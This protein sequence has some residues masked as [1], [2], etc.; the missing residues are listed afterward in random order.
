[1]PAPRP[2]PT[3]SG[4]LGRTPFA[5]LL[6]Y[7][8]DKQLT[9]TF[10]FRAIDGATASV[11]V[12]AGRPAKAQ[13]SG[14]GIY[15]GQ[16]LLELG[17]IDSATLDSSLLAMSKER[18]LHGGILVASGAIT[19]DQLERGLRAQ[20]QRKL[21]HVAQLAPMTT[22]EFHAE[23]DG[24]S[25]F[26]GEP[27]PVDPLPSVW[28]AIRA[29]PSLEHAKAALDRVSKGRL[30][31][32]RAAQIDRLGLSAEERRWV[33]L[34]SMRPLRLEEF[35]ANAE[36]GERLAR[37]L[38]Y[39]LAITKQIELVGEEEPTSSNRRAAIA[40]TAA[41]AV[42]APPS[43][44]PSSP[45][46]VGRVALR[47][48]RH[49]TQPAIEESVVRAAADSRLTPPPGAVQAQTADVA[50]RRK[51]IQ[52]V[53]A[54]IDKQNYFE[55]LG[56]AAGASIDEVKN[57]YFQLAKAWHPDRLPA[58]LGDSRDACARVF[59]RLSEAHQTLTD[60]ET[61][62]RYARL[63][64]EGGDT[65]E[66]Q[67]EIA[68][69]VSAAVEFQKAEICLKKNDLAQ[70]ETL[71]RHAVQ[72]DPVQAEYRALLA[73]LEALKPEAQSPEGTQMQI[74]AL[75]EAIKT[76]PRCERA[77]LY[78]AMLYKRQH[79]DGLAFKDFQK[80]VELN[81]KNI[82]AQREIRLHDMRG[83]G[84][85]RPSPD[86]AP[87]PDAAKQGLFQKLFKK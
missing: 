74:E 84:A 23:F 64:K 60:P 81:P 75:D 87:P 12:V 16:V 61:R 53:A 4:Q 49:R 50:A 63:M 58:A 76:N 85:R 66:Q 3:S 52:E 19:T 9:G 10:D 14:D 73:W 38:V 83:G 13:L 77:Y 22:F 27:T 78:R 2:A 36:I 29:Q 82:E 28:A 24:L 30:R 79:R 41:N 34:L 70:A 56:L 6:V 20:I 62:T 44:A 67:Q 11:L 47:Q 31:L 46:M 21:A 7:A 15:L 39:C 1:M 35:F 48:T 8:H 57:A 43:S 26:G 17:L 65:P 69:V 51:E 32:T 80:V 68:N 40:E 59:A 71:A 25:D 54:V 55:M 18:A 37:L 45:K 72:M 86:A 42:P 5:H 33:E